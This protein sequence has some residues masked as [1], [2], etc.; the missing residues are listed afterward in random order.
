MRRYS[1]ARGF[2]QERNT[3]SRDIAQLLERIL[4]EVCRFVLAL[5][6]VL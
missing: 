1:L 3:A 2:F 5:T 4:R 6:T